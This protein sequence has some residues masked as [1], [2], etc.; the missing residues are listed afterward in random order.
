MK[1]PIVRG[2]LC[3]QVI[4]PS[5]RYLLNTKGKLVL[6]PARPVLPSTVAGSPL[7]ILKVQLTKMK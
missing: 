1:N 7:I 5:E 2:R 3:R 6:S 4:Q